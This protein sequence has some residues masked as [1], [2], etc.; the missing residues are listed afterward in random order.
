MARP[1]LE[2]N[3]APAH[4]GTRAFPGPTPRRPRSREDRSPGHRRSRSAGRENTA[5]PSPAVT[6]R[7]HLQT[8]N[9]RD[10]AS[11]STVGPAR[12]SPAE[13]ARPFFVLTMLG[14]LGSVRSV[15]DAG[16]IAG[17]PPARS[18]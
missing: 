15:L 16:F 17:S 2:R 9:G 5:A 6:P 7:S 10:L 4:S 18:E 11:A 8:A 14:L 12:Q 3:A 13:R 1:H